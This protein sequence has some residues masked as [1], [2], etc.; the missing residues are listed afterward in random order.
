MHLHPSQLLRHPLRCTQTHVQTTE[1]PR[2]SASDANVAAALMAWRIEWQPTRGPVGS[3]AWH[4]TAPPSGCESLW[5][6]VT[7][8][9]SSVSLITA[10][11]CSSFR[12]P[13]LFLLSPF[14]P[15]WPAPTST[16][17]PAHS[18]R[19][20]LQPRTINQTNP[21]EVERLTNGQNKHPRRVRYVPFLQHVV[22]TACGHG[23]RSE[24]TLLDP[25]RGYQRPL[26]R[27]N[28]PSRSAIQL[29]TRPSAYLDHR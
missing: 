21:A 8:R 22:L 10:P 5:V 2:S 12:S 27:P 16:A 13:S 7:R 4:G 19:L 15:T 29:A 24:Q 6:H 25:V 11:L 18:S 17:P 26:V 20:E 3:G 14:W 23:R 9:S 1:R 28:T